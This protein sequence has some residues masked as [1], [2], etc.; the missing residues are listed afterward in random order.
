MFAFTEFTKF[1][2][3]KEKKS[4]FDFDPYLA[5]KSRNSGANTEGKNDVANAS[6]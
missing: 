1:N 4:L 2:Q 5:Y 6:K 3:F